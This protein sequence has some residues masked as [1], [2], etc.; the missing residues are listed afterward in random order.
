M[1]LYLLQFVAAA[2]QHTGHRAQSTKG[3]CVEAW[4]SSFTSCCNCQASLDA[5]WVSVM[6]RIK[7]VGPLF[8]F[9]YSLECRC[10]V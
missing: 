3:I 6:A 5:P 10:A 4:N 7:S 8:S 9:S 2:I 1:V